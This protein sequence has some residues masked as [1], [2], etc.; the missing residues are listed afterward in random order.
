MLHGR[1]VSQD[2]S[3]D[4]VV[5]PGRFVIDHRRPATADHE[6][7][8]WLSRMRA[9]DGLTVVRPAEHGDVDTWVAV[10]SGASAHPPG[11]TGMLASL[12]EPL[13]QADLPVFVSSTYSADVVLVPAE[14]VDLALEALT[15][16]GHRVTA[17]GPD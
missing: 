5:L 6:D 2:R 10:Y 12:L 17:G 3:Q 15:A 16:A 11:T 1:V 14:A 9:P 4:L 8:P 7:G 13:A